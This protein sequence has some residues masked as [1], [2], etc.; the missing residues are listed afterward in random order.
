YFHHPLY[1][2]GRTHGS[3]LDLRAKLEPLFQHYGV[4]V[5][6]AGHDH[7]YERIKP[8]QGIYYFVSG[9][10][11][12]LRKGDLRRADFT[13]TGYDQDFTFMLVEIEG[14]NLHF[15]SVTRTGVVV[16]SG[17][18]PRP[19]PPAPAATPTPAPTPTPQPTAAA[20]PAPAP[21][22]TPSP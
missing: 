13:E 8:Q 6:F 16:D 11:G 10:G 12:S 21:S 2:S 19:K 7:I 20:T 3:S 9:S 14:D 22:A 17:V 15:E 1:S 18:L 4:N 5:V